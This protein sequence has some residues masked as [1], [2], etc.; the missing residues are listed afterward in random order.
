MIYIDESDSNDSSL[1]YLAFV[2]VFRDI[3]RNRSYNLARISGKFNL[4]TEFAQVKL[5]SNIYYSTVSNFRV[6][7]LDN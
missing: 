2:L 4:G 7:G 1:N 5:A 6:S 3:S